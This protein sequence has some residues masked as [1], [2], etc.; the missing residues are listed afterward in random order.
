M[1]GSA[2]VAAFDTQADG[3]GA[4]RPLYLLNA[5]ACHALLPEGG[6]VLELG[7]GSG[8]FLAYL[9]RCRPDARLTGFD[10]S[11]P[12]LAAAARRCRREG[13]ADRVDLERRDM[14]GDLGGGSYDLIVSVFAA[15]HLADRGALAACLASI[16][17]HRRGAAVWLFDHRR[18]RRAATAQRFAAVMTPDAPA[19]FRA[20]S[21]NSLR[22]AWTREELGGEMAAA[23]AGRGM[24]SASRLLAFYQAWWLGP[25]VPR[26][27]GRWSEIPE[28]PRVGRDMR[29]L[30]RLF[31]HWPAPA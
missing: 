31:P 5:S 17:R 28:S 1:T 21:V 8:G 19:V 11:E 4:L 22:A 26:P 20:D 18:P 25:D 6:R 27:C 2:Q 24:A 9:A 3:D 13:V 12:M 15:H 30:R 16:A 14:T 10:L 23:F 7:C 29:R